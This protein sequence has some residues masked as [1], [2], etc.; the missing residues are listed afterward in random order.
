[1][2]SFATVKSFLIKLALIA[3]IAGSLYFSLQQILP[4]E[5]YF[6]PFGYL[7]LLFII[8]TLLFHVG[9]QR[10]FEKGSKHFI[11]YYMGASGMKMFVFLVIIIIF[12]LLNKKQAVA[13]TLCFFFFYLFF[14]VF[15]AVL[16]FKE[17][18]V[19]RQKEKE[20]VAENQQ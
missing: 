19:V 8:V 14:T 12:A 17:F 1:M 6:P 20:T 11:R 9:L 5:F 2:I 10:S 16:S 18:G 13:F 15:E 7:L 3:A 4:A